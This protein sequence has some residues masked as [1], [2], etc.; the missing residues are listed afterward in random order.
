MLHQ[1]H[2]LCMRCSA[3]RANDVQAWWAPSTPWRRATCPSGSALQALA[4]LL[5]RIALAQLAPAA[6]ADEF[7]AARLAP[8]VE[9]KRWLIERALL[10]CWQNIKEK[11]QPGGLKRTKNLHVDTVGRMALQEI[12]MSDGMS[13]AA[14]DLATVK[15]QRT[16][17]TA[18]LLI[19]I[20]SKIG[21]WIT[22][23][24]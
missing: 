18:L 7:E 15:L 6:I 1:L 20:N 23:F 3:L 9:A 19:I 22:G 21:C 17:L 14:W 11:T 5:H 10:P 12:I 8:Y 13:E 4:N 24:N 2:Y 16:A